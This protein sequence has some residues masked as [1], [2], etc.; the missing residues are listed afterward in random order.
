MKGSE[1]ASFKEKI[2]FGACYICRVIKDYGIFIPFPHS[3][4]LVIS[5]FLIKTLT[6]H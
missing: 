1:S 4:L 2:N 5:A 3:S 6:L